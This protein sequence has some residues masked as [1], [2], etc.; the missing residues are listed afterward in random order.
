M[1]NTATRRE[2]RE[3][4]LRYLYEYEIQPDVSPSAIIS[5]ARSERDEDPSP[6]ATLLFKTAVEHLDEIDEI[7]RTHS[8]NWDFRRISKVSL[9]VLRLSVCEACFLTERPANEI[10]V[11]EALELARKYGNEDAVPFINGVLGAA[12]NRQEN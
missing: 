8:K 3:Q 4:A 5:A 9:A 1:E 2:S 12:V 10:I 7:I 6:Y 11:N